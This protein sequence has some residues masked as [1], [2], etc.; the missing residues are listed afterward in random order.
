MTD[1]EPTARD[2]L[3][4]IP[5][6]ELTQ[7]MKGFAAILKGTPEDIERDMIIP[8][9]LTEDQRTVVLTTIEAAYE[10]RDKTHGIHGTDDG[11]GD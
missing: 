2:I 5:K 4:S 9:D 3:Y 7:L 8:D 1:D 11:G 6:P 10:D